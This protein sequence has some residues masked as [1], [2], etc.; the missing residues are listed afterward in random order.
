MRGGPKSGSRLRSGGTRHQNLVD[1]LGSRNLSMPGYCGDFA[2]QTL[3]RGF[4]KLPLGIALLALVIGAVQ[5]TNH[6]GD[7]NQIARVDL[8]FVFLRPA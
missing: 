8:L 3:E 2:G 1:L 4:V 6:F 5:V 7:R